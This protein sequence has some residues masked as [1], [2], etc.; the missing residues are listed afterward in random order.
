M[1]GRGLPGRS[2]GRTARAP[3]RRGHDDGSSRTRVV[4]HQDSPAAEPL[5]IRRVRDG[6]L[7]RPHQLARLREGVD[8][9][10]GDLADQR[11]AAGKWRRAVHCA[12]GARWI[13]RA[14]AGLTDL[15]HDTTARRDEDDPAVVRV[16]DGDE[17]VRKLVR[18]IWR[19]EVP[20]RPSLDVRVAVVPQHPSRREAEDLDRVLVFLVR[21]D[22]AQARAEEGVV[23]EAEGVRRAVRSRIPP[24][25]SLAV[26]HEQH[27]VV[28]AICDQEV[29]GDR[30]GY[31]RRGRRAHARRRA[32]AAEGATVGGSVTSPTDTRPS[33][34]SF[35]AENRNDRRSGGGAPRETPG[36][37]SLRRDRGRAP[38][39]QRV[40]RAG[41]SRH[42]AGAGVASRR[43]RL[44]G[45]GGGGRGRAPR[46]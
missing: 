28:A 27:P 1:G 37:S 4:G 21:D 29:A 9:G 45:A 5:R 2:E 22:R 24:D 42:E 16:G 7:E 34:A 46:C 11:A 26:V 20:G 35:N 30:R 32:V 31:T 14:H 36:E 41:Q 10:A 18:V 38:A 8:P 17:A 40:P 43:S 15:T 44:Q 13:V 12:E 25:E 19:V 39:R 3:A 33:I 23:V 6:R